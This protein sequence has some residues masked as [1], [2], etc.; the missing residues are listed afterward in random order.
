[1][2]AYYNI[3]GLK[4][5]VSDHEPN[6]RLNGTPDVNLYIKSADGR[7]LSVESQLEIFCERRELCIS[8]FQEIINEWADGSYDKDFFVMKEEEEEIDNDNDYTS[9]NE[10]RDSINKTNDEK[11]I[12]YSLSKSAKHTEIKALSDLT[13]VS[14]SYIKKHFNIK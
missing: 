13:G 3:K 6:T 12:G 8:D 2:S 14:Q 9:L 4:I 11:L 1:M 10:F 5:R 7:L